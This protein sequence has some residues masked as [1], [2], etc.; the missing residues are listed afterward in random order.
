MTLPDHHAPHVSHR[1]RKRLI[2]SADDYGLS[3]GIGKAIR[4]LID[5]GRLS[6][7]AC[8]TPS[9]DWPAEAALLKPLSNR[10]D[11][12]LHFTLTGLPGLASGGAAQPPS[13][14]QLV[15]RAL[16]GRLDLG[17]VAA[18]LDAQFD[19]FEAAMGRPPD[20]LDGHHHVHQLAGVRKVVVE[21]VRRRYPGAPLYVRTCGDGLMTI[22]GRR[23]QIGRSLAVAGL[24]LGFS[25]YLRSHGLATNT[26][27]RGVR[28]FAASENY[29]ALFARWL[30]DVPDGALIMC[31]PGHVDASLVARDPVTTAREAEFAFLASGQAG[32]LLARA[33][34]EVRRGAFLYTMGAP[35]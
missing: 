1:G 29:P 8:M 28:S 31:H 32:S 33:G 24:G 34:V 23:S 14:A 19:A 2:L 11:I 7:T 25:G 22:V 20:F 21:T 17:A 15:L 30:H 18:E 4:S 16:T 10:A 12:G 35:A 26:A 6:A 9:P 13:L 27:F 3:P 5:A